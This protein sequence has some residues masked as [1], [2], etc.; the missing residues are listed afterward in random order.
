MQ[1]GLPFAHDPDAYG[2]SSSKIKSNQLFSLM[3]IPRPRPWPCG[4]PVIAKPSEASGSEGVRRISHPQEIQPLIG[5]SD[6]IIEEFLDGP[7]FSIEVMGLP[8]NYQT[9]QVTDLQMDAHYDCKRVTA[10]STLQP[11][12]VKEFEEIALAISKKLRLKG[13][14]DV[15]VILHD[16]TL[17][18]LEIDARLPSQ[19]PTVVYLS[20]GVNMVERLGALFGQE[21]RH[22]S[23]S[24]SLPACPPRG[25]VYEHIRVSQGRLEVSGEHI[26][27]GAGP[28]SICSDFFGAD[29]AISNYKPEKSNWVATLISTGVNKEEAWQKRDHAIDEIKRH[30]S[31]NSYLDPSPVPI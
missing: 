29:E 13:I 10:P 12:Q 4:F 3:G 11:E 16:R 17:K 24:P 5:H 22:S 26:M 27:V 21:L 25:V 7:S 1:E 23:S 20:T 30:C 31:V 6:W 18:I 28:L 14:M 8:G 2:I 19:T 9:L 15:E